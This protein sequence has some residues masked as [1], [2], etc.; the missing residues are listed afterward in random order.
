VLKYGIIFWGGI[1]KDFKTIF[2]QQKKCVR[3]IKGEKNRVSC[4]NLFCE[5]KILTG[6]SLY[7]FE[8]ICFMKKKI[9]FVL[10]STLMSMIII[11]LINKIDICNFVILSIVKEGVFNMGTK[12]FNGLPIELKNEMNLNVFKRS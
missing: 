6:T 12:I 8:I 9:R 4:R 5:L 7:I 10:P 11:P 2:K 1:Q 3:V